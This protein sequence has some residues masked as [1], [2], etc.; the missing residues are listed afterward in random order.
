MRFI[1]CCLLAACSAGSEDEDTSLDTDIVDTPEPV[2]ASIQLLDVQGGT[3]PEGI[4]VTSPLETVTLDSDS[5][6]SIQVPTQEQFYLEVA[7]DAFITHHL[8]GVTGEEDFR[9]VSFFASESTKAL[10]YG[11]LKLDESVDTGILIVALDNPDLSP[12]VGAAADIDATHDGA[13]VSTSFGV[14]FSNVVGT[15]GFV[16]FPNVDPGKTTISV[17]PPEGK[18]CLFHPAGGENA[19]VDIIA[20]EATVA[21][22]V[23]D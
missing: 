15:G 19:T 5:A 6:G 16:A 20:N 11:L 21:F 14:A 17:T 12:A 10:M 18:T 2:T 4:V 22:F 13:F 8:T 3:L 7:A 1:L 9:L 23:C